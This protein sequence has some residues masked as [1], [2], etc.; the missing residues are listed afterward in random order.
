MISTDP[1]RDNVLI[2]K[3]AGEHLKPYSPSCGE[4]RILI[5]LALKVSPRFRYF[6][7]GTRFAFFNP[8]RRSAIPKLG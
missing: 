1:W 2:R 8:D 6:M 5:V 3:N 7:G 4:R